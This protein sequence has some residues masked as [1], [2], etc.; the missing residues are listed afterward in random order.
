MKIVCSGLLMQHP[1]G[2][3]S[4]QHLEYQV[5]LRRLGHEVAYFE[6]LWMAQLLLRSR[7]RQHDTPRLD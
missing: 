7:A 6:G 1:L 4:W 5:G 3:H 2:G